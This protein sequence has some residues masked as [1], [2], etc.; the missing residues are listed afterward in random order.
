MPWFW[1]D[2]LAELLIEQAD[3]RAEILAEWT[4]R[5]VGLAVPEGT[6]PLQVARALAGMD[7]EA[8]A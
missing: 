7:G 6:E 4:T 5:P 1:T 2:D 8:V 3:V